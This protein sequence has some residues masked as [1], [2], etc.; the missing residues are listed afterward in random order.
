MLEKIVRFRSK[1]GG[2]DGR[3]PSLELLLRESGVPKRLDLDR[4]QTR[5]RREFTMRAILD[6]PSE[7]ILSTEG[8][9]GGM[10]DDFDR[11]G[12]AK[13]LSRQRSSKAV[14]KIVHGKLHFR[15]R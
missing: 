2:P 7:I 9:N 12:G 13:E 5:V 11:V 4:H 15:H 6:P 1:L 10:G 3:A 14:R 8:K